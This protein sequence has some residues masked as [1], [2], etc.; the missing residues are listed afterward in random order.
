MENWL[1]NLEEPLFHKEIVAYLPIRDYYIPSEDELKMEKQRRLLFMVI[2]GRSAGMQANTVKAG[3]YSLICNDI[4]Y[5]LG[6][7]NKPYSDY[8]YSNEIPAGIDR[9]EYEEW[10]YHHFDFY[11]FFNRDF[12]LNVLLTAILNG[13]LTAY[14][15]EE[16]LHPL[17]SGQLEELQRIETEEINSVIFYED[18][19][20]DLAS[21]AMEKA[22]KRVVLVR[23][24]RD[25]DEYTGEYI[26]TRKVPLL[27]I[28]F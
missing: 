14:Q 24:V 10:M 13:E 3:D 11:E 4:S 5:E 21:L 1:V 26:R 2:P 22:V 8:I 6:L 15:V 28:R 19:Y 20:L 7:Y 23:H 18:W 27:L 17:S 16:P 25:Y 9:E 12:F